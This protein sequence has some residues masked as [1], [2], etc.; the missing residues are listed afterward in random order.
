MK[1]P[2]YQEFVKRMEE[3]KASKPYMS[4][5]D[6][7]EYHGIETESIIEPLRIR[8][9]NQREMSAT[10]ENHVSHSDKSV[11]SIKKP[12]APKISRKGWT[13]EQIAARKAENMRRS[14]ESRKAH[15]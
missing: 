15:E 3:L 10:F 12:Y 11:S 7:N 1:A 2:L 8:P 5:K 6:Y 13:K 14:R 9:K 4:E